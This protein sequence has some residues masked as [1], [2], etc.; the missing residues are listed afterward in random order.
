M[1]IEVDA[2]NRKSH[3]S[4]FKKYADDR[5]Y[6]ILARK[7][8]KIPRGYIQWDELAPI[9]SVNPDQV[10]QRTGAE[11][12]GGDPQLGLEEA[13]ANGIGFSQSLWRVH[14]SLFSCRCIISA[15]LQFSIPACVQG[16]AGSSVPFLAV[17]PS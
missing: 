7:N 15:V 12:T 16:R 2:K 14:N 10:R 1:A 3:I 6:K 9:A 13:I 5:L 17:A 4:A 11:E 8:Y